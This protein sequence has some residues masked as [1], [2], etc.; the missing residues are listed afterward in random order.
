MKTRYTQPKCEITI[1][2]APYLIC[3]STGEQIR[4]QED[5]SGDFNWS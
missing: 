3:Q 4:Q 5:I 1:I 2:N